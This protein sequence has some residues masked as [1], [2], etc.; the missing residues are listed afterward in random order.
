MIE[1]E[2]AAPPSGE[3]RVNRAR[4]EFVATLGRRL[5]ALRNTLHQLEED[6]ASRERRDMLQR[7]IH[8]LGSA[9]RVL[10]FEGVADA[11]ADAERAMARSAS[12]GPVA[13]TDLAEVSRA[14]DLLPSIAWGAKPPRSGVELSEDEDPSATGWPLCILVF[15]PPALET[16]LSGADEEMVEVELAADAEA[17]RELAERVG[18]DVA[19]VDGDLRG[20][21]ELIEN[22]AHDPNLPSFP[23]IVVGSFD[24]PEAASS[25]VSLGAARVLPKP[26][27]PDALWRAVL[28]ASQQETALRGPR[29]PIGDVTVDE[30]A[31]RIAAE[32]RRGLV[33]GVDPSSAAVSVPLGEGTDVL[34]AVWGA[35]ARVRELL[36]MRSRGGVR[37]TAGGP[38]GAVPLAPWTSVERRAGERGTAQRRSDGVRLEGRRAVVVDDDPAVVWFLS[39]L[40]KTSGVEV[41][42]AHDG[43]RA[44]DLVLESMPD[45]VVS[46]VLMPGMDGFSL[47]RDIKRDVAVR[48]VPVILLS[49]KEDLLQRVRELG[50]SADGYLRKEA[51]ASTVLSRIREVLRPRARVESRLASGGEVR[52]RLDGLTTRTLLELARRHQ[53]SSRIVVRDSVYL[54]ELELRDERLRSVTRTAADGSF[55]RGARVLDAL[56]GVSAGRFVVTPS[57]VHARR[58]FD[59]TLD[60]LLKPRIRRAR[61]LARLFEGSDLDQLDSV[62]VDVETVGAYLDATPEP[63]R[64]LFAKLLGGAGPREI[65]AAAPEQRFFLEQVLGDVARRGAVLDVMRD[66]KPVDLE[67]SAPMPEASSESAEPTPGPLFTLDLSPA[68]PDVGE[69]V[70]RWEQPD[71]QLREASAPLPL[72]RSVTPVPVMSPALVE[73][74]FSEEPRTAPGMGP[75]LMPLPTPSPAEPAAME[76]SKAEPAPPAEPQ[77]EEAGE[78][79]MQAAEPV[80]ETVRSEEDE[81]DRESPLPLVSHSPAT[82]RAETEPAVESKPERERPIEATLPSAKPIEFP[83]RKAQAQ[84]APGS[85]RPKPVVAPAPLPKSDEKAMGTGT[86]LLITA[87]A[88]VAAYFAITWVRTSLLATPPETASSAA[89]GASAAPAVAKPAAPAAVKL[90]VQELGLDVG[91]AVPADKG[92]IEVSISDNHPVYVDGSFVG[93]GPRRKVPVAAGPHEVM[94]KAP[95]GDLSVQVEVK[96]GARFLVTLPA[97]AP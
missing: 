1:A 94:I 50:A 88:A 73:Q 18:P 10:G 6:P 44:R 41:A 26:V 91:T 42:E 85:A 33:D 22:L 15:G 47:C 12:G 37:F 3:T 67:P 71:V 23:V 64:S 28:E 95:S 54:Y 31:Q 97:P 55:E 35:V 63:A 24:H 4:A 81:D 5:T 79:S 30:L 77:T 45:L 8:A 14:L 93:R 78:P 39:G 2:E 75:V 48:D 83:R 27:G 80:R 19:V 84:A 56:V 53:P 17:F 70:A 69:A 62:I 89:P 92:V 20:A 90:A 25:F 58:D 57:T 29:E 86:I 68:P 52:G 36:T 9:A 76:E 46:D 38:E 82:L 34:A 32:V 7:R 65:L 13:S 96:V 21:K 16:S 51:A 49:W 74:G 87:A 66:G 59:A 60:E 40:L 61:Q 11:L 43:L 72:S